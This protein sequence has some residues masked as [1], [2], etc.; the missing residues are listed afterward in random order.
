MDKTGVREDITYDPATDG[1][2][3]GD[4]VVGEKEGTT[5]DIKDMRRLGKV[6]LLRVSQTELFKEEQDLTSLSAIS[7]FSR[8]LVS[9]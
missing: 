9:L 6:Q 3:S 1:D 5:N 7:D 2:L 4:A 8:C